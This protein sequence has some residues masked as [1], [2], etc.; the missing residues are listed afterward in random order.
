ML[1]RIMVSNRRAVSPR[2]NGSLTLSASAWLR[3]NDSTDKGRIDMSTKKKN[4][5]RAEKRQ[6]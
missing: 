6:W 1:L 3:P 2:R 4:P 5:M